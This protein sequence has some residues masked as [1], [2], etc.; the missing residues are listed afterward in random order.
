[1]LRVQ[2]IQAGY[3]KI[4]VLRGIDLEVEEGELVTLVGGNGAGKTTTLRVISGLLRPWSGTVSLDGVRIDRLP[5]HEI[6]SLG[7]VHVPEGRR[8]FPRMSVMENLELG[9]RT[10]EGRKRKTENL[11]RV[12]S[13]FPILEERKGQLA[14]T[15]SGGEQQM[16]AIARGLMA[17]PRILMLDEPSQGL[18][19]LLV[20]RIFEAIQEIN[21]EG[22]AILLVEQN[23]QHA[24]RLA[25]RGYVLENGRIVLQGKGLELL[26]HAHLKR[27]YLGR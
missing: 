16:L 27:A 23:V 20:R 17:A 18:A 1:M 22:T 14:G 12:F 7:L 24:L 19:P 9:A 4:P 11:R 6:V 26:E 15:L 2:G 25:Q 8:L 21:R 13:L 3:G 10:V 5:P